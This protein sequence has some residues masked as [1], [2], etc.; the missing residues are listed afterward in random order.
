MGSFSTLVDSDLN[1]PTDHLYE[2]TDSA[3]RYLGHK[4][5][6]YGFVMFTAGG[7]EEE[8]I[9]PVNPRSVEQDEEA[10][11]TITPTQ[12]GGKFIENQG[13]IFKDI[14]ISGTTGFLP[15]ANFRGVQGPALLQQAA[16]RVVDPSNASAA[17]A[18]SKVSGYHYFHKLRTLF[19]KYLQIHRVEKQEVR[20]KTLLFWV[21]LK[22]NETWLVEP[23]SFRMSRASNSPM[24]YLYSI[25]LRTIAR[26]A[27][28]YLPPD[29]S[30][31]VKP[32][33]TAGLLNIRDRINAANDLLRGS[34]SFFDQYRNLRSLVV[35]ILDVGTTVASQLTRVASGIAD[36]IDL[37]RSLLYSATG[38]ITS[39]FEGIQNAADLIVSTPIDAMEGLVSI[40]Q[41]FDFLLARQSLFQQKWSNRWNT[42]VSNFSRT[43]GIDGDVSDTLAAPSKK[44][45]VTEAT[46]QKGDNPYTFA[47]RVTGDA[48]RAQEIIVLNNLRWPYFSPSA[49]ERL[50]GTAAPGDSLLVPVDFTSNSNN[51]AIQNT[52][53]TKT[54]SY[55][56]EVAASGVTSLT[57]QDVSLWRTNEWVGYTV[58]ILSGAGEGQTRLITANTG[59][60]LTVNAAWTV[61]PS[62][63]DLFRIYFKTVK[64]PYRGGIVELL[65]VDLRIT[66][67]TTLK[68][69]DLVRSSSGDLST[70]R[71][72]D[73]L[74]QALNVKFLTTQGELILH[75]WFGLRPVFGQRGTPEA[76]FRTRLYFEQTLLSDTRVEAVESL[77]IVQERDTYRAEAKLA[78]KGGLRSLF[79]SPLV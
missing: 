75:P 41:Q 66:Y 19:R 59:L 4:K 68:T 72:Q 49:E 35:S 9:F 30:S 15:L 27:S 65:G 71:G 36:V 6:V 25:R 76:L 2:G 29:P 62:N 69:W 26:G 18:F 1:D 63:G 47:L 38:S 73:N 16:S 39:V 23:L 54:R 52:V 32:G 31:V 8:F 67:N 13:N 70:I 61:N 45:A 79:V 40:R 5:A 58:E 78:V 17:Q 22:D 55:K 57:K 64:Q 53:E 11:V 42:A 51:N 46:P 50:P 48:T 34:L 37:P 10:A 7:A 3:Q 43:Y 74:N 60:S 33:L 12:G 77:T 24:T 56:D 44:Q 28:G 14:T 20:S 21:N